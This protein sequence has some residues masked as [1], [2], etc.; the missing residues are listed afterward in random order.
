MAVG[1]GPI[2]LMGLLAT[3][4]G[5]VYSQFGTLTLHHELH[6][7]L[8]F[9]PHASCLDACI[10]C[11][12]HHLSLVW[13][14]QWRK[15]TVC[16]KPFHFHTTVGGLPRRAG[17]DRENRTETD[18]HETARAPRTDATCALVTSFVFPRPRSAS[19]ARPQRKRRTAAQSE[20]AR[21]SASCARA[22]ARAAR[23]GS[24][25]SRTSS[26][27][28]LAHAR[29]GTH[30]RRGAPVKSSQVKSIR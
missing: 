10:H 30:A 25:S 4:P 21:G 1:N 5:G 2:G 18:R 29:G 20:A 27:P 17:R 12:H 13:P 26:E 28:E 6:K 14:L 11:I 8:R 19:C 22:R 23:A 9:R 7:P 24:E 15:D 3:G 16:V